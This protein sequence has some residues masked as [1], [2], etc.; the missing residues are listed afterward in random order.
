V[1]EADLR[2][3]EAEVRARVDADA[4]RAARRLDDEMQL[5]REAVRRTRP[6]AMFG[7]IGGLVAVGLALGGLFVAANGRADGLDSQLT[8]QRA[9]A[10]ARATRIAALQKASTDSAAAIAALRV[11]VD[12]LGKIPVAT[13]TG[14]AVTQPLD[15]GQ[16]THGHTHGHGHVVHTGGTT[17]TT[18][19]TIDLNG[20]AAQP[21]LCK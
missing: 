18:T 1:R 7:V 6:R 21:L 4:A 13:V 11:Q 17:G 19:G 3:R 14:T 9:T 15:G 5:R 10:E 8:E 16:T 12:A 20:C 2:V